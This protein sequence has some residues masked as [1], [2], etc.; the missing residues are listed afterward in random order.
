MSSLALILW[1]LPAALFM[2]LTYVEGMAN[3]NRWDGARI[4]GLA[5]SFLWPASLPAFLVYARWHYRRNRGKAPEMRRYEGRRDLGA[6]ESF[7]ASVPS[8]PDRA[9]GRT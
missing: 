2:G 8:R 5:A 4:L 3:G 6:F 7:T 1:L 9:S